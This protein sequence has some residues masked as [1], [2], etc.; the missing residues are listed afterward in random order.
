MATERVTVILE[1]GHTFEEVK[2]AI[3]NGNEVVQEGD[4]IVVYVHDP[5][6][7]DAA[8]EVAYLLSNAGISAWVE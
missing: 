5:C 4:E 8:D 7:R 6:D 1:E 3:T 2:A